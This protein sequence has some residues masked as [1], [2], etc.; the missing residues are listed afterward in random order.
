M[1]TAFINTLCELA[2]RDKTVWLLNGDLGYT[3]VEPFAE[4]YPDRYVNCGVAEQNMSGMAAG[5]ALSGKHVFTY[6]I[7]N[8]PTLRC[9]EQIR[10]D[11]CYHNASV[12]IVAVGGGYSYGSL[13]YTHH[14]IEDLAI[15]SVLPK[16]RV[17]APG[18]PVE[19]RLAL[20]EIVADPGPTYLRL[21]KAGEPIVHATPPDFRLGRAIKVREGSELT[22]IATGAML[23]PA[24]AAVDTLRAR[25]IAV[26]VLSMH[27]VK[28]IDSDAVCAAARETGGILTV[29]EHRVDGGL[30][31]RVADVLIAARAAVPMRKIGV[32]ADT[33]QGTGS[34]DFLRASMGSINQALEELLAETHF[35][36]QGSKTQ[37]RAR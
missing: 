18:D 26:R 12:T 16:M 15:M 32:A 10:N 7:A 34:A 9:L 25:G 35:A 28:P 1:R 21:G 3:V 19:T 17:I 20:G 33:I 31:S 14:G 2:E 29:E 11:I 22:V 8:F 4:R 27:T 6:S 24:V 13:G 30:G 5:L 36:R 23:N 37:V